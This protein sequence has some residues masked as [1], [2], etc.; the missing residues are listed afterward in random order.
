MLHGF[1]AGVEEHL[2]PGGEAWLVISNLAEH[3][4]LRAPGELAGLIAGAGLEV[5]GH[6]STVA[7]HP[8]AKDPKDL[9]HAARS[10]EVTTLWRLRPAGH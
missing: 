4:R 6:L 10:R 1:L 9:L 7:R 5:I 2:T 3:L 8:R